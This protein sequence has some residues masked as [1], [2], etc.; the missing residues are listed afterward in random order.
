M[1]MNSSANWQRPLFDDRLTPYIEIN[2]QQLEL[3]LRHMQAKADEAGV[4]LRPHI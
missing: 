1:D 2:A 4:A 3:N